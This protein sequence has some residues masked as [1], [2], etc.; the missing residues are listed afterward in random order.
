MINFLVTHQLV[1]KKTKQRQN[2][3]PEKQLFS[4]CCNAVS[5][6]RTTKI[7]KFSIGRTSYQSLLPHG[8]K[9][10][11]IIDET[12]IKLQNWSAK[13]RKTLIKNTKAL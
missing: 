4:K 1:A 2:L 10:L 9:P 11:K 13:K 3:I 5:K 12:P 8:I 6:H 7:I